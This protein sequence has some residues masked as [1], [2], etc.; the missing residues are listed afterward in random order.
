MDKKVYISYVIQSNEN[1]THCSET[2]IIKKDASWLKLDT[3]KLVI[4]WIADKQ[5]KLKEE[6]V[7]LINYFDFNIMKLTT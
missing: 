4:A 1:H 7:I 6:K 3:S 5:E 2:I